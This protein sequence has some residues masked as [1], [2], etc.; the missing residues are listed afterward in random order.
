MNQYAMMLA[1]LQGFG[2]VRNFNTTS[3]GVDSATLKAALDAMSLDDLVEADTRARNTA[4]RIDP[5]TGLSA[6]LI[7]TPAI[8][9]RK[10]LL[11]LMDGVLTEAVARRPKPIVSDETDGTTGFKYKDLITEFQRRGLKEASAQPSVLAQA[12]QGVTAFLQPAGGVPMW[13]WLAGGALLVGV[14]VMSSRTSRA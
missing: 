11:M 2:A 8:E 12:E 10:K 6:K 4:D 9:Q 3:G 1:G 13:V 7:L 14:V 5:Q